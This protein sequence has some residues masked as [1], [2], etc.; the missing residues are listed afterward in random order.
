MT[1]RATL[2]TLAMYAAALFVGC[3]GS[4]GPIDSGPADQSNSPTC[5]VNNGGCSISPMVSCRLSGTG[6]V[7]CAACPA[8]YSGDGRVCTELVD[9]CAL[10]THNCSPDATC[11]DTVATYTCACLDGFQGDG[12]VCQ[13][14]ACMDVGQPVRYRLN[15][16]NIPTPEQAADGDVV[17]H[18]VDNVGEACGIPDYVGN[19]DNSLIKLA[20]ALPGVNPD[21]PLDLQVGID[22]ALNCPSASVNCSRMDVI[23]SV[24]TGTGCVLM[25]FQDGDGEILGGPFGATVDGSGN[26][27][28][29]LNSLDLTIPYDTDTGTVDIDLAITDAI[30]TGTVTADSL[31]NVVIG[32]AVIQTAFETM[33]MQ[34]VP[35]LGGGVTFEDIAPILSNLY[36]VQVGDQCAATSVGFTAAGTLYTP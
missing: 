29:V 18:D 5:A 34:F 1:I 16:L 12:V 17:G 7:L 36:D 21:D 3:E 11:T 10:G 25:E 32:G 24:R 6:E 2:F 30:I 23:V 14:P 15:S 33:I 9:E 31:T 20:D 28:G 4:N 8:G 13:H 19:V 26:V 35:L 22:N 27:R